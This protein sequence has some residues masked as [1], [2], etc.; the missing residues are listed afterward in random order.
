MSKWYRRLFV[1]MVCLVTAGCV[2]QSPTVTPADAAAMVRTGRALLNCREACVAEWQRVQ[3]QAAQLDAAARWPEL[4][5]TVLQAGYQDDLSLYY[6]GRTAEGLGY[7]GAAASYYRQ[8]LRL[9]GTA[10]SCQY[11]SRVCGGVA[12]PRAAAMRLASI[13]RQ[14]YLPTR[15]RATPGAGRR[16]GPG[17]Y[18]AGAAAPEPIDSHAP[19]LRRRPRG[20]RPS[21][22]RRH[23]RRQPPPAPVT[24][25]PQPR[26]PPSSSSRR[27]R[28][29]KLPTTGASPRDRERGGTVRWPAPREE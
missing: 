18:A 23:R 7:P 25:P 15:R 8:S 28:R 6:L 19:M 2:Q 22:H 10:I 5:A 4:A 24:G 29:D 26:P 1:A 21:H 13:E 27:R 14:L 16:S 3:P 12:L 20:R 11:L 17:G 9:S